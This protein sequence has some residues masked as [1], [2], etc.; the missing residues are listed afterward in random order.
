MVKKKK[1]RNIKQTYLDWIDR[2]FLYV[3][4]SISNFIIKYNIPITPNMISIFRI[5]LSLSLIYIIIYK[6]NYKLAAIIFFIARYLDYLDGNL[7]RNAKMLSELGEKLDHYSDILETFIMI[8]IIIYGGVNKSVLYF[9]IPIV[10]Y[11]IGLISITCQ[12]R[13]INKN[14][15]TKNTTIKF[16][17]DYCP[18]L[19]FKNPIYLHMF[20][21]GFMTVG[22]SIFIWNM[23]KFTKTQS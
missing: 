9:I 14:R 22:L 23:D 8:F 2:I 15:K 3:S 13:W 18:N 20:G 6:N 21:T 7:A 1:D 5:L 12:Q 10:L 19:F 4:N 11:L 17:G 16:L